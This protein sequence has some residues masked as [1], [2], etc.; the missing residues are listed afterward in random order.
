MRRWSPTWCCAVFQSDCWT[1]VYGVCLYSLMKP[2]QL[3]SSVTSTL[4]STPTGCSLGYIIM[5][6]GQQCTTITS[7]QGILSYHKRSTGCSGGYCR[8]MGGPA[9]FLMVAIHVGLVETYLQTQN[10][11]QCLAI[12]LSL[13]W[14]LCLKEKGNMEFEGRVQYIW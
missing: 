9:S 12:T 1:L 11:F 13:L 2:D 3:W 6:K 10:T 14:C 7:P 5:L 4:F 8:R